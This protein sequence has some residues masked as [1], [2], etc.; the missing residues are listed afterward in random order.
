ML[1][2]IHKTILL[3]PLENK[4]NP[5]LCWRVPNFPKDYFFSNSPEADHNTSNCIKICIMILVG[6]ICFAV[7]AGILLY[8]KKRRLGKPSK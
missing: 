2:E 3:Q 4:N 5:T 6:V 8:Y 1:N 7:V